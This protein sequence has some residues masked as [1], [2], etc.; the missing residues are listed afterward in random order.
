VPEIISRTAA[1]ALIGV[2]PTTLQRWVDDAGVPISAAVITCRGPRF[3][4]A[5]LEREVGE[6][7]RCSYRR[8]DETSGLRVTCARAVAKAGDACRRHR[9]AMLVAEETAEARAA[10]TAKSAETQRQHL[11]GIYQCEHC[12][13]WLR[14][15]DGSAIAARRRRLAKRPDG[16]TRILCGSCA[17]V[18]RHQEHR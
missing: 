1:A 3:D 8:L 16:D 17:A 18:R 7:P 11:D 9:L 15:Q 5:T 14:V 6:L 4:R 12:G 13:Q 2:A 10:R